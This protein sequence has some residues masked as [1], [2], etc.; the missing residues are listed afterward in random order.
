MARRLGRTAPFDVSWHLTWANAWFGSLAASVGQTFVFGPVGAG[1]GTPW[2]LVGTLGARGAVGEVLRTFARV[3]GRYLNPLSRR[4]ISRAALILV[5]N[6]E[7]ERWLPADR[8]GAALSLS[9]GRPAGRRRDIRPR[10]VTVGRSCSRDVCLPWKGGSLVLRTLVRLPDH[11]LIICGGRSDEARLR[12][13]AAAM[14]DHRSC[15]VPRVGRPTGA[16]SQP[17]RDEAS[18]FLFPSL[19][20]E[21]GWVVVE[22][23]ANGLPVVSWIA[24]VRSSL[25]ASAWRPVGR[26][27]PSVGLRMPSDGP[28]PAPPRAGRDPDPQPHPGT[29]QADPRAAEG[30]S[31]RST[32]RATARRAIPDWCVP[33]T[34]N[35]P[36][37]ASPRTNS[38][39]PC[40]TFDAGSEGAGSAPERPNPAGPRRPVT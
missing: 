5:Q 15:R 19:H 2:R 18:V 4:A 12:A 34:R 29:R 27:R 16:D 9:T 30:S 26:V 11:R 31:P 39:M 32:V 23:R 3:M 14:R 24:E 25:A 22:A 17:M 35:H 8:R 21:G 6:P 10:I 37:A 40:G 36:D 7:T 28:S 1:V 33:G 20:D 38:P 13:L